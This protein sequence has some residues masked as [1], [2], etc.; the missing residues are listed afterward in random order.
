[1]SELS[2]APPAGPSPH[3]RTFGHVS[4]GPSW[5]RQAA[6]W[7]AERMLVPLIVPPLKLLIWSWRK[8]GPDEAR[9]REMLAAPQVIFA[10]CHGM[11]VHCIAFSDNPP[12][13]GRP[14]M[15]M[16]SP[17]LGGTVLGMI[18]RRFGMTPIVGKPGHRGAGSARRFVRQIR[19]GNAAVV[20]VDGSRGPCFIVKTGVLWIA[21]QAAADILVV[22]TSAGPGIIFPTWDR[23][24]LPAPFSRVTFRL[25]RIAAETL[26]DDENGTRELQRLLVENSR[27]IGSQVLPR[28]MRAAAG[29]A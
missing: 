11:L 14:L 7:M 29:T 10:T 26:G 22:T 3:R 28:R 5:R 8:D 16:V 20:A 23:A 4:R 9:W 15:V 19:A 12:R 17:S 18:L 1:M 25:D 2:Q 27:R 24:H 21:R 6:L 13:Y